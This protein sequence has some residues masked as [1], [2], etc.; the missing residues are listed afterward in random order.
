DR[1]RRSA[2][3]LQRSVSRDEQWEDVEPAA[4]NASKFR[5]VAR[6]GSDD[7]ARLRGVPTVSVDCRFIVRAQGSVMGE[8]GRVRSRRDQTPP[9]IEDLDDAIT[10]HAVER[11]RRG[12]KPFSPP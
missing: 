9:T 6:R 12:G 10:K 5:I 4:V 1:R 11:K 2:E 8:Q 3:S 7:R